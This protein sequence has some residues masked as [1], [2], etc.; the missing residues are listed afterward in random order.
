MKLVLQKNSA[1]SSA[2][3]IRYIIILLTYYYSLEPVN[4]G[5]SATKASLVFEV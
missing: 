5:L 3:L 4:Y 2:I 1:T